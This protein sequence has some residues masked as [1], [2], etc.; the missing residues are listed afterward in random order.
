MTRISRRTLFGGL[1]A[2]GPLGAARAQAPFPTR[3]IRSID[4]NPPGGGSDF[5]SRTLGERV[6]AL[7]GVQVIVENRA[8][9]ATTIGATFVARAAPDGH[10]LLTITTAGIV[11]GVIQ[12]GLPYSLERD[13]AP[14]IGV[15]SVPLAL[16]V[17]TASG[18]R[19][20][21]QLVAAARTANGISYASGGAGTMSHLAC[22]R[23]LNEIGGT[24]V[25]VP[26]RGTAPA[27][28]ALAGGHVQMMFPGVPDVR[29]VVASGH[30]RLLAVTSEERIADLPD[31][32]TTK[33]LGF[34]DFNPR[35]W[36]GFVAPAGTPQPIVARLHDAYA[37]ALQE[38]DTRGRLTSRGFTIE[39]QGPEETA[40]LMR[41]E[42]ARWGEVVRANNLRA[43]D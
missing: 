27:L 43:T 18:I 6:A 5:V 1:A 14:I 2:I 23:L 34:T 8:G 17:S 16:A 39:I 36:Y 29:P 35:L 28:Q 4:P 30:A 20:R 32:P 41:A 40:A 3:P 25:H 26:F 38:P 9:G 33:E 21:E 11:Q 19:T 22:V 37:R 15:G 10:T 13:F 42:T 7:L 31:V 24:G 12:E